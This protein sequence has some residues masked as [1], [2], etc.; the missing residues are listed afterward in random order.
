ME[1]E[2]INKLL[3]RDRTVDE[4]E[5]GGVEE[6]EEERENEEIRGQN[7]FNSEETDGRENRWNRKITL[8]E[9][10]KALGKVNA[11]SA[12]GENG[13]DY[14]VLK[15]LT[16]EYKIILKDI[17][18]E[19]WDKQEIPGE[20][21]KAIVI[22]LDKPNKKSLRPI[23]LTDCMGKI[24]ERIINERIVEWAESR[25]IGSFRERGT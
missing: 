11:K 4:S 14:G 3:Q 23:S 9:V 8:E 17:F 5:D 21:K 16:K 18:N 25:D 7:E 19:I 12:P 10:E 1:E 20:W 15:K 13:I 24:M 6:E 22:F 2:E